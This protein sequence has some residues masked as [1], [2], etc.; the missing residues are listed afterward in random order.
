MKAKVRKLKVK[1]ANISLSLC[2]FSRS[3]IQNTQVQHLEKKDNIGLR[4]ESP[5]SGE[6]GQHKIKERKSSFWRRGTNADQKPL[7]HEY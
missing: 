7:K 6:A 4:K 5:A 3:S 2:P 1:S